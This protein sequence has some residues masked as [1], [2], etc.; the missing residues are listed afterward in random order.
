MK[1]L[2]YFDEFNLNYKFADAARYVPDSL[3]F[4]LF[5]DVY[6]RTD[7]FCAIPFDPK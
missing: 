2:Q 3:E 4:F 5:G 6:H 7:S 1:K